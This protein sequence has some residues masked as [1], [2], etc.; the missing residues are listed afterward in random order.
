M[1]TV[2]EIKVELAQLEAQISALGEPRHYGEALQLRQARRRRE[3]LRAEIYRR[4][5]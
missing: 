5:K 4:E 3:M 2:A 1:M